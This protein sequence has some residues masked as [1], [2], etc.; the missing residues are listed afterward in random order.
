MDINVFLFEHFTALDFVGPVEALQR[1]D[2][3]KILFLRRRYR[4]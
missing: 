2:D 4:F 3:Y 1:I